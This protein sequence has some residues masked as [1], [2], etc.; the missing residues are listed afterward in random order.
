MF[1]VDNFLGCMT[2]ETGAL[3]IGW[4]NLIGNVIGI[5]I[6]A[7]FL[8]ILSAF[9]CDDLARLLA[10]SEQPENV[11]QLE[12]FCEPL[13]VAFIIGC[14]I[15]VVIAIGFA[16]ISI[17]CIKGTKARDHIRVKPQMVVEAV[18]T[19]LSL[20]S[21]FAMSSHSVVSGIVNVIICGYCFVVLYSVFRVFKDEYERGMTAQYRQPITK[22]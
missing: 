18:M 21:I 16:Y 8:V 19:V 20:L 7:G 5:L 2:L 15:G 12:E 3:V 1:T 22:A 10:E 6:C 17:L 13:R 11:K 9:G 4:L 14:V